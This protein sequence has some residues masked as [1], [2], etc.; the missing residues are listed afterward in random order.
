MVASE[1]SL[2]APGCM[3]IASFKAHSHRGRELSLFSCSEGA[4]AGGGG[5]ILPQGQCA[6]S[7]MEPCC[8]AASCVS[9]AYEVPFR[10]FWGIC[11]LPVAI[12]LRH[13]S[14]PIESA[15]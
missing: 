6:W 3:E 8:Q 1:P 9:T 14:P 7:V 10:A 15:V 11:V 5:Q 4:E 12:L 13:V 2:C